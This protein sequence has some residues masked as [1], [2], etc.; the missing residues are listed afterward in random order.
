MLNFLYL[1]ERSPI[2]QYPAIAATWGLSS[3]SFLMQNVQRMLHCRAS[4]QV[5][6]MPGKT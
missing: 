2:V 6:G 4:Y 1:D 3:S 5:N